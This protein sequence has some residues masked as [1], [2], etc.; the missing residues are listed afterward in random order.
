MATKPQIPVKHFQ[1]L[2]EIAKMVNA[3]PEG[4]KK[5]KASAALKQVTNTMLENYDLP[6][7][8]LDPASPLIRAAEMIPYT[9]YLPGLIRTA[10]GETA[11][12]LA[13]KN[14]M[15]G[16]GKRIMNAAI[17]DVPFVNSGPAAEPAPSARE[18]RDLMGLSSQDQTATS[19]QRILPEALQTKAFNPTIGSTFDTL[20]TMALDPNVLKSLI[21]GK[22]PVPGPQTASE[23]QAQL[24]ALLAK[25]QAKG[26]QGIGGGIMDALKSAGRF[27]LNPSAEVSDA[28]LASRFK[29]ADAANLATGKLP[30]SQVVKQS[31]MGGVTSNGVKANLAQLVENKGQQMNG[32]VD[33]AFAGEPVVPVPTRTMDELLEPV[34]SPKVTT[35][36]NQAPSLVAY[37]HAQEK[38]LDPFRIELESNQSFRN[39]RE[40]QAGIAGQPVQAPDG[41]FPL[42]RPYGSDLPVRKTTVEQVPGKQITVPANKTSYITPAGEEVAGGDALMHGAERVTS[43]STRT[44]TG[45]MEPKVSSSWNTPEEQMVHQP[46]PSDVLDQGAGG[47]SYNPKQLGDY[48]TQY[49]KKAANA[50]FFSKPSIFDT[51][52]N[53][54]A[55]IEKNSAMADLYNKLRGRA[56]DLQLSALD[57][58]GRG[59][60]GQ[61]DKLNQ[62]MAS[63]Y[64]GAPYLDKPFVNSKYSTSTTR[65]DNFANTLSGHDNPWSTRV[66]N[67][68]PDANTLKMG[69]YQGLRSPITQY[70][71]QP[72][73]RAMITNSSEDAQRPDPRP[74]TFDLPDFS[75]GAQYQRW[76]RIKQAMGDGR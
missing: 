17:P 52:R 35:K 23:S 6:A 2:E 36:M 49:G 64:S 21:K 71:L 62:E 50:G 12:T 20:S 56:R 30:L 54:A 73:A 24:A 28:A 32:V 67:A 70:G 53:A 41:S 60:G 22:P 66:L 47:V 15:A 57:D 8:A 69:T 19:N 5:V 31:N 9:S 3:L 1:D 18:Y 75:A 48:A 39:M 33:H 72:A 16:A 14:T 45:P 55:N 4:D 27:A 61:A 29:N 76:Q 51:K 42:Q 59:L 40:G 26:V 43:P 11:L 34:R 44:Y 38:V 13:G 58:T 37:R 46:P 63:V 25:Q 7:Q 10:A 74:G 68:L 65:M